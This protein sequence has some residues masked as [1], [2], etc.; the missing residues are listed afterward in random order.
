MQ[1][2]ISEFKL[3]NPHWLTSQS[4]VAGINIS[5]LAVNGLVDSCSTTQADAS[6][7]WSA[8]LRAN[9]TVRRVQMR[10]TCYGE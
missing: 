7:W 9:Y 10:S 4:S 1:C 5:D 2:F 8:K 6:P 3:L